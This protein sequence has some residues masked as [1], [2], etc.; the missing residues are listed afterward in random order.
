MATSVVFPRVQFFSNTGRPLI[1]GRIHTYVAGSSTRAP[2]YKDAARAQPNANPIILDG[3]GEASIYLDLG[4]EYKFV[5]EDTTGS[6]LLTQEPVY[7]AIWPD[8][9]NWPSDAT[10]AYQY[11]LEAK[12]ARNDAVAAAGAIGP[13]KFYD[14]YAKALADIANVPVDGL[15]EIARDETRAG[16]RTRYFKRVGNVFEFAVN[17]DQL[18]L[19]LAAAGGAGSVGYGDTTVAAAIE[20]QSKAAG[21]ASSGAVVGNVQGALDASLR[22]TRLR[23]VLDLQQRDAY[24]LLQG[25]STGNEDTEFYF[26]SMMKLAA[27]YPTHTFVYH[28][29]NETTKVWGTRNIQ[30]GTTAR[31]ISFYNGSVPGANPIYWQGGNKPKAYDGNVFDLIIVNYGLNTPNADQVNSACACLYNLRYDQP[32]AE[33]LMMLQPPD[34]TDAAMLARSQARSDAQRRVA[35]AY[36]VAIVDAFSLFAGLVNATGNVSDWYIDKI[37]P[38]AAGQQRW[39]EIVFPGML[40]TSSRQLPIPSSSTLIPNGNLTRWPNGNSAPPLWWASTGTVD[41]DTI[42]F[43]S[44]GMAAKCSGAGSSGTTTFK[45]AA[46]NI[47]NKLIHLP[48]IVIAARIYSSGTGLYPG[49]LYLA[50]SVSSGFT[51][52]RGSDNG[53][54]GVGSGGFRWVFLVVPKSFYAGKT[55]FEIGI[56]GGQSGEFVTVDRMVIGGDLVPAD[57]NGSEEFVYETVYQ[58]SAFDVP[59][60]SVGIRFVAQPFAALGAD[61][62]VRCTPLPTTVVVSANAVAGGVE[63]RFANLSGAIASI[64]ARDY[65]LRIS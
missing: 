3:R 55:D 25:D 26:L 64:T 51:D 10:L 5:V 21:V 20:A 32:E 30:T 61:V 11:M 12:E 53:Y 50:H 47:V 60:N 54:L 52:I 9:A 58:D 13:L 56:F 8:A 46:T 65:T 37:H 34:Y 14:T 40:N 23:A 24:V 2:T 27:A 4:V 44:G 29:W 33:I 22:S 36:G 16:A 63:V 6:L 57:S 38:N 19:D 31:T 35:A 18:R 43:E 39:A 28:L 48:Q 15:V 42:R 62:K 49:T 59:A 1:G 7:G 41:R 45:I 17:L